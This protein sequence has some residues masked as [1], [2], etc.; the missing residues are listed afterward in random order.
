MIGIKHVMFISISKINY[1]NWGLNPNPYWTIL[2]EVSLSIL[3]EQ[4]GQ[5]TVIFAP[6]CFRQALG[7]LILIVM[8]KGQGLNRHPLQMVH[9]NGIGLQIQ[10]RAPMEGKLMEKNFQLWL[11]ENRSY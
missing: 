4:N 2:I 3:T 6:S 11:C 7:N 1:F 5:V 8:R 10:N 9:S